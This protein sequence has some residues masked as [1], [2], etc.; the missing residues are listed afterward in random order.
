MERT[1]QESKN[2]QG[3]KD[4]DHITISQQEQQ[5]EYQP[6][7]IKGTLATAEIQVHRQTVDLVHRGMCHPI[8][9]RYSHANVPYLSYLTK[10]GIFA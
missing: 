9:N 6:K 4:R 8:K 3:K 7:L 2:H 1:L 5:L 10:T